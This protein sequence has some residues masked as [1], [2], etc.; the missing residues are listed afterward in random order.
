VDSPVIKKFSFQENEIVVDEKPKL[1]SKEIYKNLKNKIQSVKES[2]GQVCD[3][4]IHGEQGKYFE[5]L[6]KDI[7]CEAL[8]TNPDIDAEAEF[9]FPP[10]KIP[11]Y[12]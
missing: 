6:K 5:V 2:C 4:T 12:L 9:E 7:N 1:S 8:F 3:T 10:K 11:K